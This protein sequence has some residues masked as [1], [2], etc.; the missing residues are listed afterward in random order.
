MSGNE[1]QKRTSN[2]FWPKLA[3][4]CGICFVWM[5]VLQIKDEP[6]THSLDAPKG[7]ACTPTMMLI[8]LIEEMGNAGGDLSDK[9]QSALGNGI[10]WK[11]ISVG[12]I[13]L[14]ALKYS[15]ILGAIKVGMLIYVNP[16]ALSLDEFKVK[17]RRLDINHSGTLSLREIILGLPYIL[18]TIMSAIVQAIISGIMLL[19]GGMLAAVASPLALAV[20]LVPILIGGYLLASVGT[21]LLPLIMIAF[22]PEIIYCGVRHCFFHIEETPETPFWATFVAD[23]IALIAWC[24]LYYWV[25]TKFTFYYQNV[26]GIREYEGI[27]AGAELGAMDL[28]AYL[29]AWFVLFAPILC[30]YIHTAF[31][32]RVLYQS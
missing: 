11:T 13:L 22:I 24:V 31:K 14:D 19:F 2:H 27:T 10:A 3:I 6:F 1:K 9:F 8:E 23:L 16:H 15:A 4:I 21:W 7:L 25:Y 20:I 17:L 18:W 5:I 12:D 29:L 30:L 28:K 26:L 32:N